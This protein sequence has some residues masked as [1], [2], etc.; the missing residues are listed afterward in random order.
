MS[1]AWSP[2]KTQSEI[3]GHTIIAV[4]QHQLGQG[5][6]VTPAISQG[7][8][9]EL[10]C[11]NSQNIS[12]STKTSQEKCGSQSRATITTIKRKPHALELSPPNSPESSAAR[13]L[14][15]ISR[16]CLFWTSIKMKSIC[17]LSWWLPARSVR[18]RGLSCGRGPV[19]FLPVAKQLPIVRDCCHSALKRQIN[20]CSSS[21]PC[22]TKRL[23]VLIPHSKAPSQATYTAPGFLLYS[24]SF[25]RNL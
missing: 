2:L 21:S 1:M 11:Q 17:G 19:S 22:G 8:V 20:E 16:I 24:N 7:C 25:V 5:P 18:F 6:S 14:L 12:I 3:R 10:S 9:N 15:S 13:H 23:S 4:E